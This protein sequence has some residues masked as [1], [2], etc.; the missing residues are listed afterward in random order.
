MNDGNLLFA[1]TEEVCYNMRARS[2]KRFAG[3]RVTATIKI[4]DKETLS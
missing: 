2:V 1:S 3:T 4:Q